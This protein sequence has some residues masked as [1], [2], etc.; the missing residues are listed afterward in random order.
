MRHRI[1]TCERF[2]TFEGEVISEPTPAAIKLLVQT[3]G[4]LC[5]HLHCIVARSVGFVKAHSI[6]ELDQQTGTHSA[7]PCIFLVAMP[8]AFLAPLGLPGA[9]SASSLQ[10]V[11]PRRP[12]KLSPRRP[13]RKAAAGARALW[14]ERSATVVVEA[15]RQEIYDSYIDLEAMPKW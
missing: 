9:S 4:C 5:K 2:L 8:P 11:S 13:R 10:A 12:Q 3:Y 15:T 6:K 1:P 14:V 7:K